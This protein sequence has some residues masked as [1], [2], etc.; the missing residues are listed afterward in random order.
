MSE[1]VYKFRIW[2]DYDKAM[3]TDVDLLNALSH[4]VTG[5]TVTV[6]AHADSCHLMQATG[7]LDR[8]GKEVF[9]GDICGFS[10]DPSKFVVGFS[11]G[12][13]RKEYTSDDSSD[14]RR[15]EDAGATDC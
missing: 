4:K 6:Y 13:F 9:E 15:A 12:S 1:R 5:N 8:D 10:D 7:L 14:P 11:N 2:S 3:L